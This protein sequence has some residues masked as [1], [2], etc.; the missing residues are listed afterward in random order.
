MKE[1]FPQKFNE[2]ANME[3]E[4][5]AIKGKPVTMLKD[6]SKNS[7]GF[8]FLKAHPDYPELKSIDDMKG[9]PV[10]PL[11]ECN[12]FCGTNDLN[13]PSKTEGELNF[14]ELL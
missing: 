9:R 11:M 10:E 6:Q 1:D 3:H 12:G 13:G 4:L 2:M 8:V 7:T 14:M 5:T